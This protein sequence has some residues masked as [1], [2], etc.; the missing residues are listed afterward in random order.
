MPESLTCKSEFSFNGLSDFLKMEM[1]EPQR[2]EITQK[3][4]EGKDATKTRT[5]RRETNGRPRLQTQEEGGI[6]A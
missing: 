3:S 1:S 5:L 6:K 2:Y 4:S